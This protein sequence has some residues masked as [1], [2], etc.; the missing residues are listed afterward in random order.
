MQKDEDGGPIE[1]IIILDNEITPPVYGTKKECDF[2]ELKKRMQE[3]GKNRDE[4]EFITSKTGTWRSDS[5]IIGKRTPDDKKYCEPVSEL[6][7]HSTTEIRKYILAVEKFLNEKERKRSLN[8]AS[9]RL[10][11]YIFCFGL[12]GSLVL[13]AMWAGAIPLPN[14]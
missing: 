7:L 12:G 2:A 10:L 1:D 3:K 4:K 9:G 6:D 8:E 13:W 5:Y 14:L 11:K